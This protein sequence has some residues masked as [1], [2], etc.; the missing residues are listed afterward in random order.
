MALGVVRQSEYSH[1]DSTRRGSATA[2]P[3]AALPPAAALPTAPAAKAA[4]PEWGSS[5]WPTARR[6]APVSGSGGGCDAAANVSRVSTKKDVGSPRASE[7]SGRR[8][9]V[10]GF[11]PSIS[12]SLGSA[13]TETEP[14][15]LASSSAPLPHHDAEIH[16]SSDPAAPP[17]NTIGGC[18]VRGAAAGATR[19]ASWSEERFHTVSWPVSV[20]AAKCEPPGEMERQ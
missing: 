17:A 12:P 13:A 3:P 15:R 20:S 1:H 6:A 18:G 16:S 5:A 4:L 14:L 10:S 2:P 7:R 11:S 19:A 9:N 8:A